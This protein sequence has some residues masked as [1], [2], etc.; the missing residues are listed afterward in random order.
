[1]SLFSTIQMA[2]NALRINQIGL[3]VVG[4]NISNANTPGYSRAELL[5]S[6]AP[7]QRVGN[8]NLGLGVEVQGVKQKIDALLEERLRAAS[9][10]RAGAEV[11]QQIYSELESVLG[12]LNDTD[13]STSLNKFFASI[14]EILSQPESVSVRNLAVLQGKIL[15]A[16][17]SRMAN[18]VMQ[19]RAGVNNRI[20]LMAGD[21]NRLLSEI[22]QLNVR[23]IS[24]EG[25]SARSSDAVGLRDQRN[26][27]LSKL[28]E[29]ID[30]RV[31]EQP[32]GATNIFVGG[33]FLV[34]EGQHRNISLAY[35]PD[36][37]LTAASL[38]IAETDSELRTSSGQLSGL[39]VARDEILGGFLDTLDEFARTFAFEFNQVFTSGQGLKGHTSLVAEFAVVDTGVP[40]D[41]AGLPYRPF[42]GAFDVQIYNT[43][44]GL[45]KTTH[46]PVDLNGLDNDDLT[47]ARLAATL[48]AIDG[49]SAWID[50]TGRLELAAESSN[51]QFT[52]GDDTSGILAA[53]GLGTFFTGRSA[54]DLG[55]SQW[56]IADPAKFAASRGGIDGDTNNA[57]T[58]AGFIDR[59]LE[60]VGG[61]TLSTIYQQ[62]V[63]TVTQGASI[64]KAV[65]DGFWVFEETLRGQSLSISGVNLDEEAVR[66]IAYQR[67]FQ[68]AAKFIATISEMLE[69]LVSL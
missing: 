21:I 67:A 1:M 65:Y 41:A 13:L 58:L 11:Q 5:L 49:L 43:Q 63:G 12:E 32:S 7:T 53:L 46:V 24:T 6:P 25:G 45:T 66:M 28:A 36:R 19:V 35:T 15:A 59:P 55:V 68:A 37:G 27:A 29:L 51:V 22:A 44:T 62:V 48:D 18:R 23:I 26:V 8:L 50:P 10:D 17:I 54:T 57:V 42:N 56:L 69:K 34:F 47:L 33:E 9:S 61:S 4:Q 14:G 20:T 52:F 3:Q 31:D 40:L 16:D 30:I 64:T 2:G 60:T 38:K 39:L